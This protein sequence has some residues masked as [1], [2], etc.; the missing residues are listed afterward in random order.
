[1]NLR[2]ELRRA[3]G[4]PDEQAILK[5]VDPPIFSKPLVKAADGSQKDESVHVIKVRVPCVS[6]ET[7]CLN[8]ASMKRIVAEVTYQ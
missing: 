1:M 6:L 7:S 8:I 2:K 3:D 5:A 4:L